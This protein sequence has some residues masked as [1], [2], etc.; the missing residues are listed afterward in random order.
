MKLSYKECRI[1]LVSC[2][3][4]SDAVGKKFF[5]L[6]FDNYCGDKYSDD[7]ED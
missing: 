4:P 3:C 6:F 2:P 1:P 7:D 5:I